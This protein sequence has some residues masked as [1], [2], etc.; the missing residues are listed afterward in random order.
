MDEAEERTCELKDRKQE[1]IQ[2]QKKKEGRKLCNPWDTIKR[3]NL[4]IIDVPEREE[5]ETRVESLYKERIVRNFPNLERDLD[6][7]IH[8]LTDHHINST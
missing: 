1:I 7:Q 8:E 6:I 5:R 4:Q 3:N 2:L